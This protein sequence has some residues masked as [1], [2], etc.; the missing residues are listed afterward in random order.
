MSPSPTK[1]HAPATRDAEAT[2]ARILDAAETEFARAGLLGA[3]TEA[4]AAKTGVTK[5]MIFYHFGDKEGLYQ[6]VLERAVA[7]RVTSI[8]KAD[9]H[10]VDAEV[11]LRNFI[12]SFLR[13]LGGNH[14]IPA[15]FFY[16]G[17]QNKGKFYSQIAITALYAPL[18]EIIRRGI[19]SGQFREVDPLHAAVN[20]IGMCV[21]YYCSID[22]VKHLWPPGTNPLSDEMKELHRR[23][24]AEQTVASVLVR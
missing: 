15:I 18:V 20:M 11:A 19:E 4:I 13:D 5:S 3:R 12:D 8:Q 24:A 10:N 1:K 14:Q 9:L 23:M 17:I 21:F 22:N 7:L 2:K 6:A 16:E